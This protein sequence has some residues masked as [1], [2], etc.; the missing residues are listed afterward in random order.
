MMIYRW[1]I[2]LVLAHS[3]T[4]CQT[5]DRAFE[6][7]SVRYAGP[8]DSE[9]RM[10]QRGG[11]GTSDPSRIAYENITLLVLLS[12]AYGIDF[13]QI[14][15]PKWLDS[16]QYT[17]L[18][19]VPAGTT[20]GQ[21][22]MMWQQLLKERFHLSVHHMTKDFPVYELVIAKNGPKLKASAGDPGV[23]LPSR[24]RP[25][26][27]DDGFPVLPPG[28]R[29]GFFQPIENGVQITRET[30]RYYSMQ[31]LAQELAW[32]LG[33]PSWEHVVSVGRIVDKTGLNGRYDFRLE[34]AGTHFPGGAFPQPGADGQLA[35]APNL[36]DAVQQQLGLK[37]QESKAPVD[38]LVVDHVDKMPTEN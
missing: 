17:V 31:E 35:E 37:L 4:Y 36:F 10:S 5:A 14:T 22:P 29:H 23:P 19:N 20:K 7:A 30:F 12:R 2:V 27:G 33:L 1:P 25:T 15:G 21:L 18:A 32:P 11:P 28:V 6:V 8:Y 38:I 13:D 16:N 34:Y 3:L 9:R 26:H 24:P